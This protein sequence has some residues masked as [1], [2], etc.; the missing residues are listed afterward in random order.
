MFADDIVICSEIRENMGGGGATKAL[1]GR[2]LKVSCS[3][4]KKHLCVCESVSPKWNE[5]MTLQGVEKK[6]MGYFKYQ[7]SSVQS[8]TV[9]IREARSECMYVG[10]TGEKGKA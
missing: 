1:K 4:T 3:K 10:T 9:R 7:G 6:M 2:G 8:N 5:W